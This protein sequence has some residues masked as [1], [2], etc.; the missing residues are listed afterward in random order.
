MGDCVLTDRPFGFVSLYD[1]GR[2]AGGV[3]GKASPPSGFSRRSHACL[4]EGMLDRA[5]APG[6]IIQ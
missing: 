3:Q 1:S 2:R 6:N 5:P 4:R